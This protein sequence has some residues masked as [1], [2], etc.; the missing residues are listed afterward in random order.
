MKLMVD[1]GELRLAINRAIDAVEGEWI[2]FG[3][4]QPLASIS[5]ARTESKNEQA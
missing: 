1:K 5:E 4:C 3:E 2:D